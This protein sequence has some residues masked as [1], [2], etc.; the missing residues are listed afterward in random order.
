MEQERARIETGLKN[1]ARE[2]RWRG[3]KL[4]STA[5]MMGYIQQSNGKVL[6]F[7]RDRV[8][9]TFLAGRTMDFASFDCG[10][11]SSS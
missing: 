5:F 9:A 10:K 7:L 4:V 8:L 3:V 11:L 6:T 2:R 1:Y